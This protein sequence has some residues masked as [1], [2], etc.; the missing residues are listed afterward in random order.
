MTTPDPARATWRK[1]TYSGGTGGNCIEVAPQA[2]LV[3]IRDSQHR[4]GPFLL[5]SHHDWHTFTTA[6]KT[7]P[8]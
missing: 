7:G 6:L 4:D 1:S 8:Q 3:A 2:G 5:I